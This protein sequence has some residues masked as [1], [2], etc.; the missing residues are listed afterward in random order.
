LQSWLDGEL[1]LDITAFKEHVLAATSRT[2]APREIQISEVN[3]NLFDA[4]LSDTLLEA[5]TSNALVSNLNSNSKVQ[6]DTEVSYQRELETATGIS[7]NL[8]QQLKELRLPSFREHYQ[9]VAQRAAAESFSYEQYLWELVSQEC[10]TRRRNRIATLERQSKLPSEKTL[11]S[12]ELKRLSAKLK[13]QVQTLLEGGFVG[14]CEN[15]LA[16]GNP[17]SGKTHL[18]AA[19]AHEMIQQRRRVYYQRC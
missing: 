7:Q 17:G 10:Q 3:L 19:I 13:R 16:F 11:E 2:P 18:L 6:Y 4:L 1:A 15:V 8:A 12:F 9:D 14:R 5:R